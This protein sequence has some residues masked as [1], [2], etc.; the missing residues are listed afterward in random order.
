MSSFDFTSLIGAS[1]GIG[2]SNQGSAGYRPR[3]DTRTEPVTDANLIGQKGG[4]PVENLPGSSVSK[5]SNSRSRK[6]IIGVKSARLIVQPTSTFT[7]T[8]FDTTSRP[9]YAEIL[10]TNSSGSTQDIV[11]IAIAGQTVTRFS[12]D[13]GFT[14]DDFVDYEDIY[15]TGVRTFEVSNDMIMR[16][17]QVEA[18]ADYWAKWHGILVSERKHIYGV[19]LYG[20]RFDITPGDRYALSIVVDNKGIYE[21]IDS[22]VEC[23]SV[24]IERRPGGPGLTHCVFREVEE[25]WVKTSFYKAAFK[26]LGNSGRKISRGNTVF[27]GAADFTEETSYVCDGTDDDVQIQAAIDAMASKGG[28]IVFLSQGD[29]NTTSVITLKENVSLIG[30]GRD[31]T[32][33]V[34]S[35]LDNVVEQ[36][37]SS[38][39]E[40]SG[41][42]IK[43]L[44]VK[45]SD[46][47]N[48]YNLVEM[49]YCDD[50]V[51]S[52]VKLVGSADSMLEMQNCDRSQ[53]SKILL[54]DT[55]CVAGVLITNGN[56]QQLSDIVLDGSSNTQPMIYGVSVQF[57]GKAQLNNV[58]VRDVI[59]DYSGVLSAMV[60]SVSNQCQ[61]SNTV[62][63]NC[64]A[65]DGSCT[66]YGV[67]LSGS[68]ANLTGAMIDDVDNTAT[69]SNS[70][71]I[72]AFSSDQ[73]LSSIDVRNCSGTGVEVAGVSRVQIS[74]GRSTNNGTNYTDSGTNTG[75]AAFDTT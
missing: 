3:Q 21:D 12:G 74:G 26:I 41:I 60:S 53:V 71:G 36:L 9:G 37:A 73:K 64:D 18:I 23:Y 8:T 59:T 2:G 65:T 16:K 34:M 35:G 25:N 56:Q 62:V 75:T 45:R 27:V 6:E 39:S 40:V 15:N 57:T 42:E 28:G 10:L 55:D 29:F 7:T 5:V 14:H 4:G 20:T 54:A 47:S 68:G 1:G 44:T 48:S 72:K 66:I 49:H 61:I 32:T 11:G 13:D 19:S 31:S 43:D 33:I 67:Y 70:I 17:Q 24:D 38:G 63:T 51:I 22:T 50:V 52:N 30:A 58:T 46:S 69:A